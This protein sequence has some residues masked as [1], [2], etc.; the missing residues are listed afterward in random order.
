MSNI[1]QPA[2]AGT[3]ESNDVLVNVFPGEGKRD[4]ELQSIVIDQFGDEILEVVNS[5][6][7]ENE[8]EDIKMTLDDRGALNYTIKARVKTALDRGIK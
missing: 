7:D 6:L 1:K 3:L 4:I 5:V 2:I 8:I